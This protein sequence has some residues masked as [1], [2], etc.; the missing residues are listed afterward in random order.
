M[1]EAELINAVLAAS[2][3]GGVLIAFGLIMKNLPAVL[4]ALH[5]WHLDIKRMNYL[6]HQFDQTRYADNVYLYPP[7]AEESKPEQIEP[8]P[9]E[10][11]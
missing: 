10:A 9:E 3:I 11:A 2:G 5:A 7:A 1:N 4:S 6:R 8:K